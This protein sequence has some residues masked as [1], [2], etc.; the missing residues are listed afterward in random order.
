[1]KGRRTA[2][3]RTMGMGVELTLDRERREGREQAAGFRL[4][5]C[6]QKKES[7]RACESGRVRKRGE[8]RESVDQGK[9]G[10]RAWKSNRHERRSSR[11]ESSKR[12]EKK[13]AF[14]FGWSVGWP[15][16]PSDSDLSS[17]FLFFSFRSSPLLLCPLFSLTLSSRS[18]HPRSGPV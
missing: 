17:F 6:V 5:V 16:P 3:S 13:R 2:P 10:R 7:V 14:F 8:G 1:V 18:L 12:E 4:C 11:V 9:D 15:D